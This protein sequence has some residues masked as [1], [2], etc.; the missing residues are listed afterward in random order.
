M[1]DEIVTSLQGQA[2]QPTRIIVYEVF[3]ENDKKTFN[4]MIPVSDA[5]ANE[6]LNFEKLADNAIKYYIE[7]KKIKSANEFNLPFRSNGSGFLVH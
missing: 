4:F 1:K 3:Y 5:L 6:G 7:T 2:V